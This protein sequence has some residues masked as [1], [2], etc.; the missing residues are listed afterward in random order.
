MIFKYKLTIY[1]NNYNN[2]TLKEK[3][4]FQIKLQK[5][6]VLISDKWYNYILW[7]IKERFDSLAK[8]VLIDC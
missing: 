1:G 3:S 2:T 6:E 5:I 8:E 4:V 7:L